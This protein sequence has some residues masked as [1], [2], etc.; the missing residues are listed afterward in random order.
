MFLT[1]RITH[2]RE[3]TSWHDG[4]IEVNDIL[5][6]CALTEVSHFTKSLNACTVTLSIFTWSLSDLSVLDFTSV[7]RKEWYWSLNFK[8]SCSS[9]ELIQK[10]LWSL[11]DYLSSTLWVCEWLFLT[12]EVYT[13][14]IYLRV[15]L[16]NICL[17]VLR[18]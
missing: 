14:H 18:T 1:R 11:R 3:M 8:L 17:T 9:W 13:S 12:F 2:K 6:T 15:C 4:I 7:W 16:E 5:S 10:G